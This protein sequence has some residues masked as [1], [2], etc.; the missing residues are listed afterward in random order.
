LRNLP[1]VWVF[2]LVLIL[3]VMGAVGWQYLR[4]QESLRRAEAEQALTSVAVL[5]LNEI[6]EWRAT[7][8]ADAEL[9]AQNPT[10]LASMRTW[11]HGPAQSPAFRDDL[12]DDARSRMEMFVKARKFHDIRVIDA[13]NRTIVGVHAEGAELED[14]TTSA[15]VAQARASG[16]VAFGQIHDHG[17][18]ALIDVVVPL[19]SHSDDPLMRASGLVLVVQVDP[20]VYLY[21][22]LQ[23]WPTPS[24]SG[25]TLLARRIG[26]DVVFISPLRHRPDSPLTFHMPLSSEKLAAAVGLRGTIGVVGGRDYRDVPILAATFR[27]D[28]T[29]WIMVSKMDEDEA[30]AT[31]HRETLMGLGI[32]FAM[33]IA[34]VA[35]MIAM[36][37][38][39]GSSERLAAAEAR[40]ELAARDA[41]LGAIFRAA[42]IG[43]GLV[44]QRVLLEVSDG[45]CRLTGLPREE[46]LGETSRQ[47]YPTQEEFLRAGEAARSQLAANGAAELETTWI[48]ADGRPLTVCLNAA[49]VDAANPEGDVTFI[50][51]D[52]TA[53]KAQEQALI[54]RSR[55]LERSNK[56]LATFAYVASHDLRSPLRGIAQLSDWIVEDMPSEMPPEIDE[57]LKLMRSR[58]AR[59]EHL[60]DD[61]LSYSRVGRIEGETAT[62]DVAELCRE[63]FDLLAPPPGFTLELAGDLPRLTT[64]VAPLSQVF[65]NLIGNALKHRDRDTGTI[66]IS[67]KLVAGG[68]AYTVADDGPGIPPQFHER[69]FGLFQTLRPR[70]EVEGSGMG[71]A[72][73]RKQVELYGGE[74]VV[75]SDGGRGAAFEFTWPDDA[76]MKGLRNDRHVA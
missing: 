32:L 28:G 16:R 62:V 72:L 26:D 45:F 41:W 42:P 29:D 35:V 43:I 39:A 10:L 3:G 76:D 4:S 61:L 54:Q 17:G 71:L 56:E 57:H 74:I 2:V 40:A 68:H 67:G 13:A 58:V 47:F 36:A 20:R 59:M 22:L 11:Y 69:I 25:E 60:L 49:L 51:T 33:G 9:L 19:F 6:A 70:D 34:I 65:Q 8:I 73:V 52:I 1:R 18:I 63:S 27:V 46:M 21:P 14:A 12:L 66:T 37:E 24:A 44:R 30:L 38:E 53:R 7:R 23:R 31:Q 75:H 15:T 48:N 5:K 55:E 64:R 50:V